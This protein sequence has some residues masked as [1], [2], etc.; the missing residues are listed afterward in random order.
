MSRPKGSKNKPKIEYVAPVEK[1]GRAV[2]EHFND[3]ANGRDEE[4]LP[5]KWNEMGK[6]DRLK[7]LTEHKR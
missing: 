1:Y 4:P 3:V 2:K 5:E 7:W 6:I